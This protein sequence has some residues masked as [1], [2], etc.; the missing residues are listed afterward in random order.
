MAQRALKSR[1]RL[2]STAN[3][4]ASIAT[5]RWIIPA[6]AGSNYTLFVKVL[7]VTGE[8]GDKLKVEKKTS[9]GF[10]HLKVFVPGAVDATRTVNIEY[11]VA[12][13]TRFFEDHDEFYWNVTGNDWPVPIEQAT[14]MIYFPAGGKRQATSAGF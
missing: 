8:S 12:N 6:R 11:S 1:S 4:T 13:G 2:C 3:I 10:L 9:N 7:S 5:F 14:A